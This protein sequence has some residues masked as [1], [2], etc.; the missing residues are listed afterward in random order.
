[1][2]ATSLPIIPRAVCVYCASSKSCAPHHHADA[3]RLGELLALDGRTVIYGGSKSGS[4][5]A[6]ADGALG[7][8]GQVLGVL[9]NFLA[10]MELAHGSLSELLLVDDMRTRKHLM[11]S[12]S[13]AVIAL[14]GG[15]GT[16]EELLETLTLKRL[17][18]W[19]GPIVIVNRDGYYEPLRQLLL[20]AI[21]ERFMADAH[22]RM[23]VMV[24][25]VEDALIALDTAPAWSAA[26]RQF[27]AV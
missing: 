6:L 4:M 23:W 26:A 22:A 20:A 21:G 13:A 8:G 18:L 19:T 5:G 24:E 17:G 11:L 12:R 14:P 7:A 3:R 1:M 25:S 15:T 27:A 9:P 10:D 2:T 16:F